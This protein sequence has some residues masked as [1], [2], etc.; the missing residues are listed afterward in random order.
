MTARPTPEFRQRHDVEPPRVDDRTFRQGWRVRTRLDQL[1]ADA[2]I[3]R[4]EWQAATEYRSAWAI[5]RELAAI[6]PGM[7]RIA[8]SSSADAAMIARI[9]AVT[10]LRHVEDRIGS[11]ASRFLLACLVHDLAWA[12]IARYVRK[13]PQ[14]VRDWTVRAIRALARVWLGPQA[15]QDVPPQDRRRQDAEAL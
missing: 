15:R 12:E 14:T 13:D 1:L 3:T 2:R 7:L 11:D 9:D 5:A 8:G 10:Q 6:E 4:A